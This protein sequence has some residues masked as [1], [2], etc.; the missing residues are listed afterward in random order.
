[1]INIAVCNTEKGVVFLESGIF[2][3]A[4]CGGTRGG[5]HVAVGW[6]QSGRDCCITHT[7]EPHTNTLIRMLYHAHTRTTH[8]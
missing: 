1:M 6:W 3:L 7:L 5:V 4:R 2:W 8:E